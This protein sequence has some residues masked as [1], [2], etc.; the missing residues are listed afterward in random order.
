VNGALALQAK[1][2]D[3]PD[4]SANRSPRSLIELFVPLIPSM[5]W[6]VLAVVALLI[7]YAPLSALVTRS[8]KLK[9]GGAIEL[10]AKLDRAAKSLPPELRKPP[11]N[12]RQASLARQWQDLP[13]LGRPYRVLVAHD[14][15]RIARQIQTAFG[16]L[17]FQTDVAICPGQIELMLRQFAY[18]VVVSDIKWDHCTTSGS[19]PQDGIAFLK[20]AHDS[21][22]VRPTVFF[23]ADYDPSRGTPAYA[24]GITNNWYDALGY[25]FA[26]LSKAE[27]ANGG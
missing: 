23:I 27:A 26:V 11:S 9:L 16:A 12:S 25:V 19:L 10:E 18:D 4:D 24:A 21:G 20:Y 2:W 8:T 22:F 1:V 3:M 13:D 6:I 7:F 5:L 17:A 14:E 15:F